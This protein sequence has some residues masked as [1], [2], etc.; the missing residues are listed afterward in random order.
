MARVVIQ[1]V[2]L[3][4]IVSETKLT[5]AAGIDFKPGTH[6]F[7]IGKIDR[8][9]DDWRVAPEL[10]RNDFAL[11]SILKL[12]W[13]VQRH[14]S[15]G[16]INLHHEPAEKACPKNAVAPSATLRLRGNG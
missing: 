3:D 16:R 8:R 12:F 11:A 15:I 6:R 14:R 10:Q 2:F 4:E 7:T 13:I 5:I 9:F 1:F